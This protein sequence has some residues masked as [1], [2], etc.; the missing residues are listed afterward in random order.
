MFP[1]RLGA[2]ISFASFI[3]DI[4]TDLEYIITIPYQYPWLKSIAVAFVIVPWCC[5]MLN[6]LVRLCDSS[7]VDNK[8]IMGELAGC[9]TAMTG[10]GEIYFGIYDRKAS[11]RLNKDVSSIFFVPLEDLPQLIIE[12]TNT[13]LIGRTLTP[14]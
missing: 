1:I 4:Y 9:I 3:Y 10:S 11:E 8:R 12:T 14:I 2:F 6:L 13:L 7:N 5:M